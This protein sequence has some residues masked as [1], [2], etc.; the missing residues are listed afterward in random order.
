MSNLKD[1]L[2]NCSQIINETQSPTLKPQTKSNQTNNTKNYTL[3]SKSTKM[4]TTIKIKH[5][6][7]NQISILKKIIQQFRLNRQKNFKQI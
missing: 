4:K 1:Q 6:Q 5:K 7:Q 3:D 2:D